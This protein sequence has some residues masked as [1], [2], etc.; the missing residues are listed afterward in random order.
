MA[1]GPDSPFLFV[2]SPS[3][4]GPASGQ[5]VVPFQKEPGDLRL[6]GVQGQ[7]QEVAKVVQGHA[8]SGTLMEKNENRGSSWHLSQKGVSELISIP[9]PPT[10]KES[11]RIYSP[12]EDASVGPGSV[13][14][15]PYLPGPGEPPPVMVSWSLGQCFSRRVPRNP[16]ILGTAD[17]RCSSPAFPGFVFGVHIL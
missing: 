17:P 6:R 10:K 15:Q 7:G 13:L 1:N 16:G 5:I 2:V 3:F 11:L 14:P 8:C 12:W 4:K 9:V